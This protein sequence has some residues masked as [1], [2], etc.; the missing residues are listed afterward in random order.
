MSDGHFIIPVK[1]YIRTFIALLILTVITVAVSRVDLGI[2]NTPLAIFVASIKATLVGMYFMGL[3][4]ER[5]NLVMVF[6]GISCII[7]FCLFTFID[8]KTRGEIYKEAE[9]AYKYKSPV[10]LVSPNKNHHGKKEHH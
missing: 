3:R 1:Y 9:K 2:L 6:G 5:F 8:L 4:W 7:L 10:K